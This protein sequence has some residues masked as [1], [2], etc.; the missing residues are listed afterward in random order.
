VTRGV[1][2]EL[3][4]AI[5]SGGPPVWHDAFPPSTLADEQDLL[6]GVRSHHRDGA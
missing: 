4:L 2:R 5:R 3:E 6:R 1:V